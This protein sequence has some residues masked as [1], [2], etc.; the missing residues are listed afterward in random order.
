LKEQVNDVVWST[1]TSSV[2]ASVANDGRIEIWD[3]YRDNLGPCL[4]HFDKN[5]DGENINIPKTV[6]RFS[7][8]APVVLTGNL[9]GQVDVYRVNGLEHVQVSEKDQIARLL[10]AIQKDDFSENKG[11]KKD[12]EGGEGAEGQE[13]Q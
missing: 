5:S 8:D 12:E 7:H 6:V 3:L 2:F 4:T 1:N 9:K 11:K 10:S 13:A